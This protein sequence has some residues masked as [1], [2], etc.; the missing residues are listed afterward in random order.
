M[1]R[2][3]R[4]NCL[5]A[6][7]VLLF[8]LALASCAADPGVQRPIDAAA[9]AS[10]AAD[11]VADEISALYDDYAAY[12]T[13]LEYRLLYEDFQ[14]SFGGV[15]ISMLQI[16]NEV[17]VY[18]IVAGSPAEG[19]GIA[20][21][22]VIVAVDGQEISDGDTSA[23]AALIRGEVGKAVTLSLRRGA[24]AGLYEVTII[25]DVIISDTVSG[26]NLPDYPGAAYIGISGFNDL[27]NSEF[28]ELYQQLNEERAI[29]KLILDLRS[30]GGG[31]FYSCIAIA[32]YFVPLNHVVVSEKT[33]LGR[34]IYRSAKGNLHGVQIVVLQNAYTASA[35]E[36]LIG[37]LRDEADAILVGSASFGKGITQSV[38]QLPSGSGHR[39]TCSIYFTPSGFSLHGLGLEPDII[40]EDPQQG[41]ARDYFSLDPSLNAHLQ[42]ALDYL[43]PAAA[44]DAG[45]DAAP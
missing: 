3:Q 44:T 16:D 39:Y 2:K 28:A 5:F 19:S 17:T 37:A 21:G 34:E 30:N 15:G 36:V 22:D 1:K 27:T 35:S 45:A 7:V 12:Y 40:V 8:S 13:P 43:F 32:E 9:Y 20:V 4:R 24:D 42:A 18:S 11:L 25:R 33:V 26:A 6:T 38:R 29:D 14:G 41:D 10:F 31:N 23:A